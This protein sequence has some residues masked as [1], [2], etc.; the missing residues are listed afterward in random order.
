MSDAETI[1][2]YDQ[3]AADYRDLVKKEST[4]PLLVEFMALL[5]PND[6]VLDLGCGPALSSAIMIKEGFRVD[7]VDASAAMVKMANESFNVGARQA[8]FADIDGEAIYDGIWASFC[9]LHAKREELPTI[10]QALNKSLKPNGVMH[11][12][13][14]L[15]EGA[16]RDGIGRFYTYYTEPELKAHLQAANFSIIAQEQGEAMSLA[17]KLE[18]WIMLRSVKKA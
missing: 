9:L 1:G 8:T 10:L 11:L 13:M 5:T 14:K 4:H 17:G 6:Y 18:P 12:T 3:R 16:K 15:G 7:P 2:V